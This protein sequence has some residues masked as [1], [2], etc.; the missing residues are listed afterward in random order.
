VQSC[1]TVICAEMR[2]CVFV[3]V[4]FCTVVDC[5]EERKREGVTRE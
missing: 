2:P 4:V 1:I 5:F 3:G